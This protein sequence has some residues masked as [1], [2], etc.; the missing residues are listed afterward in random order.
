MKN[1]NLTG[2]YLALIVKADVSGF[3]LTSIRPITSVEPIDAAID[4]TC[5][6][7]T[8]LNLDDITDIVKSHI[9][10]EVKQVLVKLKDETIHT[11]IEF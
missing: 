4:F 11:Y 7:T 3:N 10:G 8:K 2:L 5:P 1:V 6:D 9:N